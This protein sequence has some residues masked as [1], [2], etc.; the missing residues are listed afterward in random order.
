M[1][2]HLSPQDIVDALG[3]ALGRVQVQH[4]HTCEACRREV[5]EFKALTEN[6]AAIEVP[7]PSPLFW[8]HFS[9]RV[10]SAVSAESVSAEPSWWRA[11]W[12]PIT[13]LAATA[14]AVALVVVLRPAPAP[15]GSRAAL[16]PQASAPAAVDSMSD[17]S[18]ALM[19]AAV[20]T[21][22]SWDQARSSNLTPNAAVVDAAIERLTPDQAAELI[23]LIRAEMAG[24]E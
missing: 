14:A 24:V 7:E 15:V 9:R 10:E 18:L 4:L 13:M 5:S 3:G 2:K 16:S 20:E 17:T 1:T 6:L 8:E 19:Q 21:E 23:R 11:A 12:R 22:I